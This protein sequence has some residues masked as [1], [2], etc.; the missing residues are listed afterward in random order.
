MSIASIVSEW[1]PREL[2]PSLSYP[3]AST[4]RV[5]VLGVRICADRRAE[6][7]VRC[8]LHWRSSE[9]EEWRPQTLAGHR[10]EIL[11]LGALRSRGYLLLPD[12]KQPLLIFSGLHEGPL[13]SEEHERLWK[14]FGLPVFEQIRG[15]N[16]ELLAQEC[17]AREG[18]HPVLDEAGD[19]IQSTAQLHGGRWNVSTHFE[20]CACGWTG[21]RMV[22][23]A[24]DREEH[25]CAAAR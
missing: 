21:W 19:P 1:V 20:P 9:L 7:Q 5:A 17:D 22:A 6:R 10:T 2:A 15:A 13:T 14:L 8:F 24:R 18:W 25:L 4:P 12:L 16:E 11:T 3:L 23:D